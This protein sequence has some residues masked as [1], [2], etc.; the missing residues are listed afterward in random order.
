MEQ[1]A[2]APAS[3]ESNLFEL[4]VDHELSNTFNNMAKWAR[5][6]GIAGFIM[7]A[8]MLLI[9]FFIDLIMAYGGGALTT[10]YVI[11]AALFF[12]PALFA[13]N[14]SRK[15]KYALLNNDQ[16]GLNAAFASLKLRFKFV[17]IV[18]IV[19]FSLWALIILLSIIF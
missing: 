7:T 1:Y 5:F 10:M 9:I 3:T 4:E 2:Q 13:F 19:I 12:F 17:G 16:Q 8:I 11:M 15:L 18:Y 6:V 14:F